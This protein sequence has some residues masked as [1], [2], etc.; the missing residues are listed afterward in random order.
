MRY[1]VTVVRG[2]ATFCNVYINPTFWRLS[3]L[4]RPLADKV[5]T[6]HL[7]KP[8]FPNLS[9]LGGNSIR[10]DFAT[11]KTSNKIL[12]RRLQNFLRVKLQR[13]F[14]SVEHRVQLCVD[15]CAE[16]TSFTTVRDETQ[17]LCGWVS[18]P[19]Y[20]RSPFVG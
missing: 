8:I 19:T 2:N 13:V 18:R 14:A 7:T 5:V 3:Y 1:I 15:A 6:L 9:L 10:Q 17:F 12:H 16:G 20:I 11:T 4:K